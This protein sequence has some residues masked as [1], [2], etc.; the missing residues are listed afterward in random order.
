MNAYRIELRRSPLLTALPLMIVIDL[1]VLFGRSRYWIGVW[2]DASVAAQVVTLFLGPVLAGVSTWQAGRSSRSGMPE[3]VLAAARP[4][5]RIEAARLAATLTLGFL[6]YA[7]GCL[8]AAAISFGDAGPGFLWSSYLL[9]GASTLVIFASGGHLAGRWWPS[10]AFTPAVCALGCF[11][12]MLALPF[13][14][15]VLAGPPDQ[16]LRPL[17]LAVRI[18]FALALAA[19][20][21][22]APPLRRGAER[23]MQRHRA[24]WHIRGVA[25]GS[26]VLSLFAL[27]AIPAAG[28]IRVD[29]PATASTPVCER[30]EESSPR[31]CAWPEHRKYLAE[32]TR[33]AQRLDQPQPWLRA[34]DTFHEFGLQRS[35]LGDR[36]FDIAEGHV[37]TAAIAMADQVLTESLG[38]CMF[39]QEEKRAWQAMHN[40]RLWL[41]YRSMDQDPATADER[42][43]M[44]GVAAAQHTADQ[45]Y[46][47]AETEQMKWL[48]QERSHILRDPSW[49]KPDDSD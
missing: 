2:P 35:D 38:Q 33:M 49:C 32:L 34:P 6:A 16:H 15:N 36:G 23:E 39:P 45:V 44:T 28:E 17:P 18:L 8:T 37:R 4:G 21:V 19:L 48:T 3:T 20:A 41:E 24:P 1:V 25:A 12:S 22:A 14:L 46:R 13:K 31:V 7:I 42:L 9:L 5:W 40:I 30:V 47:A 43:H 27:A 29:R 11:I 26:A 10:V